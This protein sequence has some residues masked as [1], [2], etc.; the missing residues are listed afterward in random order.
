MAT[1]NRAY[2][3][4]TNCIHHNWQY[5]K[6]CHEVDFDGCCGAIALLVIILVAVNML[7]NVCWTRQCTTEKHPELNLILENKQS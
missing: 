2:E 4:T 7:S 3:G 5:C 6:Q 1:H